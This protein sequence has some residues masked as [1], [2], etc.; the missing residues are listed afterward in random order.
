MRNLH[1]VRSPCHQETH[2]NIDEHIAQPSAGK[3]EGP[4][5]IEVGNCH[6]T[7]PEEDNR[8]A[9]EENESNTE[10][11]RQ[12]K[13][14]NTAAEH[15]PRRHLLPKDNRRCTQR[16]GMIQAITIIKIFIEIVRPYLQ[17]Q[18]REKGYQ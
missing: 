5:T 1:I 17:E 18:A 12:S 14:D 8:R 15:L 4:G 2:S 9:D 13:T 6:P 3:F 11:Y 16:P 7:Q 10:Q